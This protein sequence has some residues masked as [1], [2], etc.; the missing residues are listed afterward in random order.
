[1]AQLMLWR[2]VAKYVLYYLIATLEL[3][4]LGRKFLIRLYLFV[5]NVQLS[6][7]VMTTME[8]LPDTPCDAIRK[9]YQKCVSAYDG[10]RIARKSCRPIAAALEECVAEHIGKLD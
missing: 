7:C 4:S 5:P 3:V 6:D 1:V 10:S 9:E 8:K 2:Q